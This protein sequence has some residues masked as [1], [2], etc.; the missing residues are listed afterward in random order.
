MEA[1]SCGKVCAICAA[2]AALCLT[3]TRELLA[4]QESSPRP[5]RGL[6]DRLRGDKSAAASLAEQAIAQIPFERLTLEARAKAA[7]VLDGYSFHRRSPVQIFR[8][9]P[10]LYSYVVDR[11]E[12]T[13]ALWRAVGLTDIRVRDLG[14]G[15]FS[16]DDTRGTTGVGELLYQNHEIHVLYAKGA[17]DGPLFPSLARASVLIILRSGFFRDTDGHVYVTHR[18]DIFVKPDS[19]ATRVLARGLRATCAG[20]A[21]Q[22]IDEA[23]VLVAALARYLSANERHALRLAEQAPGLSPESRAELRQVLEQRLAASTSP[24]VVVPAELARD[25]GREARPQ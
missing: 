8:A 1:A 9:D 19:E 15:R 18:A 12:A 2:F 7:E 10:E 21:E 5:R 16:A 4:Q 23:L 3:S 22:R 25:P 17:Y 6:I 13:V 11:P 20:L 14:G 24:A